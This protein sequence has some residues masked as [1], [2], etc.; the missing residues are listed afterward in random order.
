MTDIRA[1]FIGDKMVSDYELDTGALLADAGLQTAVIISLFTD[2]RAEPDDTL[3]AEASDKRG[4][5]GDAIAVQVN[6]R[7]VEDDRIG[8][9][10]WLL[11]R[12]KQLAS[13]VERARQYCKEALAWLIEDGICERIDVTAEIVR[14]GVLGV[15]IIIYRPQQS[16]VD[17]KFDYAWS[18]QAA[19]SGT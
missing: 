10:L 17:F 11:S 13:V 5:W 4:W 9:R 3:P 16:A 1:V 2:R 15:Q 6:G 7:T 18:A 19:R 12:E 8:S 14:T